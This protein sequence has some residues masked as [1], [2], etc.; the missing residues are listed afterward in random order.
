MAEQGRRKVEMVPMAWVRPSPGTQCREGLCE[1]QLALMSAFLDE[2]EDNRLPPVKTVRVG[3]RD[4]VPWDGFHRLEVY[5]RRKLTDF[6]AEVTDGTAEDA[7]WLAAGANQSQLGLRRTRGDRRRAIIMAIAARPRA[8]DPEVAERVGVSRSYVQKVRSHLPLVASQL[9][10]GR[11]GRTID[12][13]GIGRAGA[14]EGEAD[15]PDPE[16][17]ALEHAGRGQGETD[18][19]SAAAS[20]PRHAPARPDVKDATGRA[21]PELLRDAFADPALREMVE[22]LTALADQLDGAGK[23]RRVAD[24]C[25]TYPFI[26][27]LARGEDCHVYERLVNAEQELRAIASNLAAGL[28]HAPCPACGGAGGRCDGCRGCGHVPEWRLNELEGRA[29]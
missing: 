25:K 21:V 27:V 15:A 8:S 5:R 3:L 7:A 24:L 10:D 13:S 6:T 14:D 1:E 11:D 18:R 16:A 12:V 4:H 17:A 9:R 2:D 20:G 28:P 26:V 29:S 23:G 19:R 22:G